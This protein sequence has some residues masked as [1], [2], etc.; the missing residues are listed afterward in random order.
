MPLQ[1]ELI[2][3]KEDLTKQYPNLKPEDYLEL[4]YVLIGYMIGRG[5]YAA[6]EFSLEDSDHLEELAELSN[7]FL[8]IKD[9]TLKIGITR[10]ENLEAI[11]Q[12]S[13]ITP[14]TIHIIRN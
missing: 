7:G 9:H 8:E 4:A 1:Q 6:L 3:I 12:A 10:L 14:K 11:L 13:Y 2:A 5:F